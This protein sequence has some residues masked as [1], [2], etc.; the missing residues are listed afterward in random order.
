MK[1]VIT[2]ALLASASAMAQE[3]A[4]LLSLY[5]NEC[6]VWHQGSIS[7]AEI[8]QPLFIGDS[9]ITGEDS[10]AEISFQDGSAVR[11]S[12]RARLVV[13]QA[14]TLRSLKLFWGKVW[15]R[16]AKLSSSKNCF[17]VE[18]PTAVAGVR[19]TV[20]RVEI[21]ADST[22]RVA[23]EEGEVEVYHPRLVRRMVRLAARRQAFVRRDMDP[24]DPADFDP[25][26][27]SR[28][29][30]WSRKGFIRLST[31]MNAGLSALQKRI[32]VH[33]SLLK[34]AEKLSAGKI[35]TGRADVKKISALR[36][37][38]DENRSQWRTWHH[39]A[40]AKLRQMEAM[41]SRIE[42]D[43][44]TMSLQ[45][46]VRDAMGRLAAIEED[47]QSLEKAM[48]TLMREL[49]Q[50][51][52]LELDGP[53]EGS[54]ERSRIGQLASLSRTIGQQMATL[55]QDMFQAGQKIDL[56][57][58]MLAELRLLYR[59]HPLA[60]REKLI[61][62]RNDYQNFKQ[63]NHG[64]VFPALERTTSDQRSAYSESLRLQRTMT[65]NN[66]AY[67]DIL[68]LRGEIENQGKGLK[69]LQ[70][71]ARKLRLKAATLERQLF[72]IESLIR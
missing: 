13:Q 46:Q 11:I 36:R 29:E 20:F 68:H 15:A 52:G 55:R 56:Y 37:R 53:L 32:E 57:I 58:K 6:Q 43:G 19:G 26:K 51:P 12:D 31:A 21:Q 23:V 42:D 47:M 49:E 10:R 16:I 61:T 72:E 22:T 8:G 33:E 39:Q 54:E 66:P 63:Q 9:V 5:T 1:R 18:T 59:D 65:K 7:E 45:A 14:D 3:P 64:L 60:A 44:E 34:S 62:L 17:Q 30:R 50:E 48:E 24:S 69:R 71:E 40:R 41:A 67:N 25:A 38:L 70:A 27:E 2:I 4:A 28:W 35:K